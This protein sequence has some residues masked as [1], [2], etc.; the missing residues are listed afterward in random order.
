[1]GFSRAEPY[2]RGLPSLR[3]ERDDCQRRPVRTAPLA[4]MR[5][6][7][8]DDGRLHY[9]VAA[10]FLNRALVLADV[11]GHLLQH[12]AVRAVPGDVAL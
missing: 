11:N 3:V 7:G 8:A 4:E 2:A 5:D 10:S 6:R 12:Y 1:M 9:M